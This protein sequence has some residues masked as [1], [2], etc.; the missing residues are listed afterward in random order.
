MSMHI[1]I[2]AMYTYMCTCMCMHASMCVL[3]FIYSC[4]MPSLA[5]ACSREW[6]F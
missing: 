2:Y 3:A 5:H 1:Y 4:T 6:F